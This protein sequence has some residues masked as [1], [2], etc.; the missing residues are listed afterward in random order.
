[1]SKELVKGDFKQIDY[2]HFIPQLAERWKDDIKN[3]SNLTVWDIKSI[4]YTLLE[5]LKIFREIY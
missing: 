2:H 1:M 4:D 3:A 5:K